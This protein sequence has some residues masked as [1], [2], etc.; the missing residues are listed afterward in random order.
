VT[1]KTYRT[2]DTYF[3]DNNIFYHTCQL[4]EERAYRIAIKYLH[5][6]TNTEDIKQELFELGQNVRN[7]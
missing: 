4:K 6:S 7:N 1:P 3:K 2:P 5:H